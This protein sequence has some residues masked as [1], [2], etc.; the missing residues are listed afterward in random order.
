M[1]RAYLRRVS[2]PF[3]ILG[4]LSAACGGEGT[5]TGTG[6]GGSTTSTTTTTGA[7]GAEAVCGDGFVQ[8]GEDCDNGVENADTAACT[9]ACKDAS[10]G[11]SLIHADVEECDLGSMNTDTGA[12]TTKCK[13]AACGDGFMQMGEECDDGAKNGDAA[14]CTSQCKSATCG[15]SLVLVGVEECDLGVKNA[16][17]NVCTATCKNAVCGDSLVQTGVEECDLGDMNVDTGACTTKCKNA[18]CGD[19]FIQMGEECDDAA[20]NGDNAA[21]TSQCKSATCGDGLV[22]T[23]VEEC[24]LGAMNSDTGLC[25]LA[26]K[27]EK[28][29]DG[30]VG[31]NEQ[32]DLGILNAND[33]VCTLACTSAA[34]GDGFLQAGE[35]CDLGAMNS[36]SG[37]C[38]LQCQPAAC[39]D[40]FVQANVEQCDLGAANADTGACTVACKSAACGDG[41][42]HAGVEE[43]DLAGMN[44]NAGV[45]TLACK[46]AI[47]G[48]GLTG[49]GEFCDDGNQSNNDVCNTSCKQPS[50]TLWTQDYSGNVLGNETLNGVTT[51]AAGDVFTIGTVPV[52]GRDLDI[53]VRHYTPDG[54][55]VWS[56]VYDGAF[57]GEDRGL[58][59]S[60]GPNGVI[61]AIGYETQMNSAKD[62]WVRAY[63]TEG[64]INWTRKYGGGLNLDDIGYSAAANAAGEVFFAATAQVAGGQGKDIFISKVSGFNGTPVVSY[65]INGS[66]NLDDEGLG[67]AV[68]VNND[69]LVTGYTRTATSA[70]VWVRKYKDNGNNFTILWTKTFN[71]AANSTDF[72]ASITTDAAANV[73]V[74]GVETVANQGTNGWIRKYDPAG[75]ILWT[76]TYDGPAHLDDSARGVAIDASGNILVGGIE[77]MAGG[78][79]DGWVR[80]YTSAGATVWTSP[81][82]GPANGNDG[83]RGVSFND[84]AEVYACGF[85]DVLDGEAQNG[86]VRRYAP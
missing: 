52:P 61:L 71:G 30:L 62:V 4:L 75:N 48:D 39:G 40:G 32:C 81:F 42:L 53:V 15:D 67:I 78:M 41:L 24:D 2:V 77:T 64:A 50:T 34:C 28:C 83:V 31:P 79:T 49:P 10:C 63:T 47:C 7:G 14:A 73:V 8:A 85:Y 12:C 9:S 33:G 76:Q 66:G 45:C 20:Q 6:G 23:G 58:G 3:A 69:I 5:P 19:G 56:S 65:T 86:W 35:I 36:N 11:D 74:A 70:D 54:T 46:N 38:T 16:D 21:C 27:T 44:S 37:A 60:R 72:G 22:H 57:H 43:C 17:T 59:I 82:N 18:V 1:D 51:D 80:R 26:C 55:L 84:N 13:S 68:D 29:G 25:T